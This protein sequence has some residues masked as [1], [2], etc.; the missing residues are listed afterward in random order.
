MRSEFKFILALCLMGY[1]P[2][3]LQSQNDADSLMSKP[4]LSVT[5]STIFSGKKALPFWFFSNSS[6]RLEEDNYLGSWTS[7]ELT[8]SPDLNKHKLSSFYGF[9]VNGFLGTDSRFVVTQAFTGLKTKSVRFS[10]GIQE[11]FFGLNDST[12]S[13]GNLFYGNNA[14]P[15]PKVALSTNGWIKAPLLGKVLSFNAYFAHGWLEKNR[16]Q[17]GALLHQK[18]F[19]LKGEFLNKR[20]QLMGGLHHAAHWGG[21]N[22]ERNT[23]QP[24]ALADFY[25]IVFAL[26]GQADADESDRLNALGNHLGSYDLRGSI[27][28]NKITI[29]NYWQFLW[30]DNSGLNPLNWRDGLMGLSIKSNSRAGLIHGFNLEIIRTTDQN[31]FKVDDNGNILFEP[32]NFFN[33]SIYNDGWTYQGRVISNPIFLILNPES[34]TLSK[35]KNRV[36][37]VNIAMEGAHR[38]FAYSLQFRHFKNS[39]TH[40]E[41]FTPRLE[42]SSIEAQ[43][44][45]PLKKAMIGVRSIIEWGNYPG[46]NLGLIISYTR[47]LSL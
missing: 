18:Y 46:K 25:R 19:Y 45:V 42:L 44:R 28:L 40:L 12:L 2:Y 38:Q 20:L 30:E 4:W 43:L 13:I 33:N 8:K 31:A 22:D 27:R 37:G 16:F 35:V 3:T 5:Q 6:N 23:R 15:I 36:N 47:K 7:L 10:L 1:I 9:E 34:T 39:G 26:K 32:D 11:E 24:K 14:S 41:N 17:S 29:S 21:K